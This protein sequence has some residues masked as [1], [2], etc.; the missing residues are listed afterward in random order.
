M[1]TKKFDTKIDLHIVPKFHADPPV[2]KYGVDNTLTEHVLVEPL[3]VS[4]TSELYAGTHTL[5]IEFVNKRNSDTNIELGLD[6]T[7][8][9]DRIKFNGLDLKTFANHSK[10][11]PKYPEPWYSQQDSKP[12]KYITGVQEL[13]WNGRW[14]LSFSAPIFTWIHQVE[15][16]GWIW[17]L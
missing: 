8:L 14:E 13:G 3:V 2:I 10:Y 6:K 17:P 12:G 5:C 1:A 11:Y 9:I 16:L 15:N 4:L 7:V